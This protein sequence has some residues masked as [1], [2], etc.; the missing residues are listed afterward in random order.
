MV[1]R[2]YSGWR[3]TLNQPWN[4]PQNKKYSIAEP[5][6]KLMIFGETK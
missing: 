2:K 5:M 1:E 4:F 6:V 3:N